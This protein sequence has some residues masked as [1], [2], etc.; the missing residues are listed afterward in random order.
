MPGQDAYG[1]PIAALDL[2]PGD[3]LRGL[4]RI[5][6]YS[7]YSEKLIKRI[8]VEKGFPAGQIVDSTWEASK[9]MIDDWRRRQI[10][11]KM[12]EIDRP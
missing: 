3:G 12:A 5:A 1:Q 11:V 8:A 4:D 2:G 10:M 6:A 9:S 7:G